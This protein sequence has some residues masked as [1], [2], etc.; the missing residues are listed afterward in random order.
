VAKDAKLTSEKLKSRLSGHLF[1]YTL[2]F[3]VAAHFGV[4]ALVGWPGGP[5]AQRAAFGFQ[6]DGTTVNVTLPYEDLPPPP[7]LEYVEPP[8]MPEG[9]P[10]KGDLGEIPIP[11]PD[12]YAE[13]NTIPDAPV[14]NAGPFV[15]P[16]SRLTVETPAPAGPI[17]ASPNRVEIVPTS[18]A[19]AIIYQSRPAYPDIARDSRVEGD[20]ILLVYIDVQGDVRNVVVQSSPGLPALEDAATKAA[21]KCKFKPAEQQGVPVGV[22]YSLVMQFRL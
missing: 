1:R 14:R 19:P 3:S 11:V 6:E 16:G 12:R 8:R 2:A 15:D 10:G 5:P 18:Q 7:S 4:W 9:I 21:Y 22:W 17:S 13:V 20:V